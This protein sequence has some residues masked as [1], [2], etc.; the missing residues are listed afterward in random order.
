[1]TLKPRAEKARKE[2]FERY[3]QINALW[4]KAEQELAKEHIPRWFSHDFNDDGR[5][6]ESLAMMKHRG[7]WRIHYAEIDL[8]CQDMT[9]YKLITDCSGEIRVRVMREL[10][11]LRQ[12]AVE[13]AERFVKEADEAICQMSEDLGIP[14][15]L[16]ELLA[17]RAK[18]NGKPH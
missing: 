2:L 15:N 11:G 17:E 6:C 8:A 12:A 5:F 9:E 18:L 3:D 7:E 14:D 1:M 4:Q 13:S 16:A 10:P